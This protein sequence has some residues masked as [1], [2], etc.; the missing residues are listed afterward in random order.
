MNDDVPSKLKSRQRN[1][2]FATIDAIKH[3]E[4]NL[5]RR[6]AGGVSHIYHNVNS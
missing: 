3:T 1:K 5:V 6:G 2:S 4:K